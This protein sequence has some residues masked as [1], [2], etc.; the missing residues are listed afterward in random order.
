MYGTKARIG[1]LVPSA[2][3][4]AEEEFNALKPEG[5]SVHAARMFITHPTAENLARMAEDTESATK[6][7]ATTKP[8][9]VA[10]VCTTGSLL[11]G[12]GWDEK[13]I[14][15]IEKIAKVPATTT[16]T[17]VIRAFKELKITRVAIGTPYNEELNKMEADFFEKSGIRVLDIK[18]LDLTSEEMNQLAL[19]RVMELARKVD[20][21]DADAIFL[22]CTNLKALPIVEQLEK[23]LKKWVFSSNIATYW[24]V[25]RMLGIRQQINDKGMPAEEIR[26]CLRS[27]STACQSIPLNVPLAPLIMECK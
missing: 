25:M 3:T 18:G 13:L 12:L 4:I 2:N 1:I 20:K 7:I 21:P 15:R 8:N 10:F 24:D 16:A 6:M 26:E 14:S 27:T 11:N 22:S 19:E 9:V 5:V 23:E 17:A